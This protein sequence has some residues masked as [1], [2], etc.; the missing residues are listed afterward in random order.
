MTTTQPDWML[1]LEDIWDRKD[2]AG[3]YELS[4]LFNSNLKEQREGIIELL[5][6]LHHNEDDEEDKAW[7][8]ALDLAIFRQKTK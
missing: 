7:N 8:G 6:S 4:D 5:W 1:K 2:T 3:F